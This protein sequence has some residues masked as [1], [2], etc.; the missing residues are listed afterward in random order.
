M[1]WGNAL[2][3]VLPEQ[4]VFPGRSKGKELQA[5]ISL[6]RDKPK[7]RACRLRA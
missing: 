1:M 5:F 3:W 6:F 7:E 2:C 4:F